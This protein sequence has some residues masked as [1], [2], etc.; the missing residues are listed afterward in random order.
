MK[1]M[2]KILAT[3]VVS[4][5]MMATAVVT[6]GCENNNDGNS[7]EFF[8][9]PKTVYVQGQPLDLSVGSIVSRTKN[10]VTEIKLNSSEVSVQGYEKDVLGEQEITVSYAGEMITYQITVIPALDVVDF[11]AQYFVGEELDL[12]KGS[13]KVAQNDGSQET[14]P[15]NDERVSV[16]G[17]SSETAGTVTLTVSYTEEETTLSTTVTVNVYERENVEFN[18]DALRIEYF[19]HETVFDVTGGTLE[20]TSADGKKTETVALTVDMVSGFNPSSATAENT[21][22]NPL[23]QVV[24]LTYGSQS[25][26]FTINVIYSEVSYVK[27]IAKDII[28]KTK[29]V[30]WFQPDIAQI[31]VSVEIGENAL[32]ALTSYF[33]LSDEEKAFFTVEETTAL[34]RYGIR[35]GIDK[36]ENEKDVYKMI[37]IDSQYGYQFTEASSYENAKEDYQILNDKTLPFNV[38]MDLLTNVNDTF[39]DVTIGAGTIFDYM[40]MY[41]LGYDRELVSDLMGLLIYL[42]D[43]ISYIPTEWDLTTLESNK[44]HV[45]NAALSIVNSDFI[46]VNF[47]SF[48]GAASAW[49]EKDD[50][51]DI[52]YYYYT[53][54]EGVDINTIFLSVRRPA[55]IE[56]MFL[57]FNAAFNYLLS[58]EKITI[59]GFEDTDDN[60]GFLVHYDLVVDKYNNIMSGDNQFYKD[61]LSKSGFAQLM[62]INI[63]QNQNDEGIGYYKFAGGVAED[64]SYAEL[65]NLYGDMMLE[66]LE[67]GVYSEEKV[68]KFFN[69][70]IEI[71]PA[72]QH[73]FFAS[74][75]NGY[76]EG[77]PDAR[78]LFE[79]IGNDSFKRFMVCEVLMARYS[80]ET[81][82]PI[83]SNL[84]LA[85]ENWSLRF[86][87][88][89]AVD[90]FK[91]L[92]E[93]VTEEYGKITGNAKT[94]FDASPMKTAYDKYL[95]IYNKIDEY[96]NTSNAVDFGDLSDEFEYVSTLIKDINKYS[97]VV[98]AY[99]KGKIPY[100]E[101]ALLISAYE[102]LKAVKHTILSNATQIVLE[103]Y[104]YNKVASLSSTYDYAIYKALKTASDCLIDAS[105]NIGGTL[106]SNARVAYLGTGV[107]EYLVSVYGVLKA[108]FNGTEISEGDLKWALDNYKTLSNDAKIAFRRIGGADLLE[109]AI[110]TVSEN[111]SAEEKAF[112][113]ALVEVEKAFVEFI[114]RENVVSN[115]NEFKAA[116]AS[117]IEKQVAVASGENYNKFFKVI[118]EYYLEQYSSNFVA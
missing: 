17:F 50:I 113:T 56:E 92:M 18:T 114:N 32:S 102:N 77:Q 81:V 79:S 116:M 16:S 108:S 60:T 4:A 91:Y 54:G 2:L 38:L 35:Y 69:K 27:A 26:P 59:E 97:S 49:R 14:V 51:F 82:F 29:S 68:D 73:G 12:T 24:F 109:K 25:V 61:I 9:V 86:V 19:S 118:Y 93:Y 89:E 75:Y 112:I 88:D 58:G 66:V 47:S 67:Q 30:N 57:Q 6:T 84:L 55:E 37:S 36:Y 74:L 70:F 95:A 85:I 87:N 31:R 48:F 110:T 101:I 1:K 44:T 39:G 64:S 10:G 34:A 21:A 15:L 33:A 98:K 105:V 63:G 103:Y 117:L 100:D 13:V 42:Y 115:Q 45:I 65:I 52:I 5:L 23:E 80:N 46:A 53:Y 71:T 76:I 94:E 11:V 28:T 8:D 7:V 107:E 90:G 72:T 22:E 83:V 20:V 111:F 41:P 40:I 78:V 43:E 3:L 62:L 104:A 99:K 96:N 106:T